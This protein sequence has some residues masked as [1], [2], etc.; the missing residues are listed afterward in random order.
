MK[1]SFNKNII[2][3]I[4][5]PCVD[6]VEKYLNQ[7]EKQSNKYIVQ[8]EVLVLRTTKLNTCFANG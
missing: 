8:E 2:K 3:T 7:W 4:P 6:Q 5:Q 1:D